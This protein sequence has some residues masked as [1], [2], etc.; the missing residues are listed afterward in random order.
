MAFMTRKTFDFFTQ[1]I[2]PLLRPNV[3]DTFVQVVHEY[4]THG[5]INR[6]K[7]DRLSSLNWSAVE[8]EDKHEPLDELSNKEL[9]GRNYGTKS[10]AA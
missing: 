3:G 1:K 2:A 7:F 6:A 5:Y 10:T 4:Y 8:Q 9:E